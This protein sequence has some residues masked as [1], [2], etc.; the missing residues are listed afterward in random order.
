MVGLDFGADGYNDSLEE[1]KLL[2]ASAGLS[3]RAVIGGKRQRP[4]SALFAGSGKV[5]EIAAALRAC[6]ASLA[7]FNHELSP[8]QERNLEKK[9]GCRVMDRTRL[10]L[11][12][13]AQR[14]KTHEGKLQVE[15]AQME[16]LSTRLIRGWTH[17][18]RQ[19]GGIGLR[20]GPGETQLELDRRLLSQKIKTLKVDL[21][22]MRQRRG[23]QRRARSRKDVFSVSLVGYT[24]AGKSTLFNALTHAKGFAADQLFATLDTT[25][26]RIFLPEM[27]PRGGQVVVSDTVG[28]IRDLPTSLIAAFRATLEETVQADL[29]LHVVD[30]ASAVRDMQIAEVNKVLAEIGADKV[31]QALAMNKIDLANGGAGIPPGVERDEYGKIFRIR[32]SAGTGAGLDGLRSAI[33]ELAPGHLRMSGT[34]ADSIHPELA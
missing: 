9:L 13:F 24:N 28:F 12:I 21:E 4:D 20:G 3:A 17:L 14:A 5:Q 1:L 31:P 30:S 32:V 23:V 19:R 2:T 18:E 11:E 26:R 10:I 33:A 25:T 29:L 8:A 7:V 15:L 16:Y 34:A 6:E 22:K 27:G